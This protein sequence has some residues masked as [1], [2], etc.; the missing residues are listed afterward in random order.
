MQPFRPMGLAASAMAATTGF[1]QVMAIT[2]APV[3]KAAKGGL[4]KGPAHAQGGV[5][6]EAEGGEYIIN[7]KSSALFGGLLTAL[8]NNNVG[9][10]NTPFGDGGYAYR[11]LN[12]QNGG[13]INAEAISAAVTAG[14]QNASVCVAI[15]DIDKMQRKIDISSNDL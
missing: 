4:I 15:E 13:N 5:L 12:Q 14:M 8:N 7:K 6:I 1:A 9:R 2:S 10:Y 11:T 3:P